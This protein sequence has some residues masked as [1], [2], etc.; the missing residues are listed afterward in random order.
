[1]F[2]LFPEH[3]KVSMN[4]VVITPDGP[5]AETVLRE[6]LA[7]EFSIRI[8]TSDASKLPAEIADSVEVF[9]TPTSN[10][11]ALNAAFHGAEAVLWCESD[12]PDF[13]RE[14]GSFLKSA[15]VNHVVTLGSS[16]AFRWRDS[17]E[18]ILRSSNLPVRHIRF[19]SNRTKPAKSTDDSVSTTEFDL[20]NAKAD[21]VDAA[22]RSLI[23][24]NWTGVEMVCPESGRNLT[25]AAHM[26]NPA[27]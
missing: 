14:I 17:V 6:L 24:C 26:E 3:R 25:T 23:R 27:C 13:P 16:T 19:K 18:N 21:V 22:L 8:I 10:I 4:I 20:A 5:V 1:M 15:G 9:Q 7:P 2:V 12:Q 11:A